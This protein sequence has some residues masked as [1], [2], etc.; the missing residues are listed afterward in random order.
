MVTDRLYEETDYNLLDLSLST[1]EHHTTTKPEFFIEPGTLCKVYEE[2][3]SPVLFV[4]GSPELRLDIQFI[5]NLDAR[6]NMR[7]MLEGLP[8]LAQKAK[9]NGFK[10][11]LFNTSSPLLKAFCIKR[12][13]FES[14]EGDSLRKVL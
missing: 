5:S 2:S 6:R 3:G 8:P 11:I 13:G 4:R 9:D 7:V 12:F 14:V 1:D 10:S